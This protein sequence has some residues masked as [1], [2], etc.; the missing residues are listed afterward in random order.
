MY[1]LYVDPWNSS[2]QRA[3][4]TGVVG[5]RCRE[6][7]YNDFSGTIPSFSG[8]SRLLSAYVVD[9]VWLLVVSTELLTGIA[10]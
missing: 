4:L 6:L 7:Q 10:S 3:I 1:L 8:L 2:S 5:E 9:G